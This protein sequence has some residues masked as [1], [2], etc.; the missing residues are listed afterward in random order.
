LR[1]TQGTKTTLADA[2]TED[3]TG[4]VGER[5]PD[6]NEDLMRP[7]MPHK[8]FTNG[9][10]DALYPAF[11]APPEVDNPDVTRDDDDRVLQHGFRLASDICREMKSLGRTKREAWQRPGA[12]TRPTAGHSDKEHD[13]V[14]G[15]CTQRARCE[16]RGPED[17][18]SSDLRGA[19]R[20]CRTLLE[21]LW[22]EDDRGP[23]DGRPPGRSNGGPA[24]MLPRFCDNNATH[25]LTN[26][27]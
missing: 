25:S 22:L 21:S 15:L 23:D 17:G 18:W 26:L 24:G 14:V 27:I 19:R 7:L 4:E 2:A 6:E 11:A 8:L 1:R 16:V 5:T 3:L 12:V 10:L 20:C 13:A 9:E